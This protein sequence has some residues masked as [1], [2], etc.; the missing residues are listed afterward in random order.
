MPNR[1]LISTIVA[2][3]IGGCAAVRDEG[4]FPGAGLSPARNVVPGKSLAKDVESQMGQP[5]EKL[6]LS[7]GES[8]WFY[9]TGPDRRFTYAVQMGTDNVVR[10]V[11]QRLLEPNILT[12]APGKSRADDV[13]VTLGP[14]ADRKRVDARKEDVW[15][16]RYY[17]EMG[18]MKQAGVRI[19]D[20]GVVRAIE[21]L[22]DPKEVS[23]AM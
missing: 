6:S 12:L 10:R 5:T 4:A 8:L 9:C 18:V 2:A 15:L 16:Y 23:G 20:D 21:L 17:D 7:N 13:K 14:P 22:R 11:D 1:A 3:L 19:G